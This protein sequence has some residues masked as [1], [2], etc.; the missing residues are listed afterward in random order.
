MDNQELYQRIEQA[1]REKATALSL[2]AEGLT[3]L[4]L[5]IGQLTSLTELYLMD[6]HLTFLP[7]EID[8]LT[9][10]REL[11]LDGNPLTSPP[12][13]IVRQ[14]RGGCTTLF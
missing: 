2:R 13:E 8:Q 1:R 11:D 5:E 6:N 9:T 12:L 7:P 3:A 10:L 14:G 4:P